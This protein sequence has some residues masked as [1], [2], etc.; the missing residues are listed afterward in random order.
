MDTTSSYTCDD[1][2]RRL[3]CALYGGVKTS[4]AHCEPGMEHAIYRIAAQH[5]YFLLAEPSTC[6]TAATTGLTED[7]FEAMVDLESSVPFDAA[8]WFV[9]WYFPNSPLR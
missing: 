8:D 5:C 9:P 1:C 7:D 4:A 3:S 6:R 2:A